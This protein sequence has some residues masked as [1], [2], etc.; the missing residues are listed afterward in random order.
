MKISLSL[1]L[2]L[3]GACVPAAAI[4]VTT[5]ANGARLNSPFWLVAS[6]TTC[7]GIT[8]VSMGYSIDH[9]RAVIESTS[10]SI[11]VTVPAGAHVLHVKCWG[12]K[13]H[14]QVSLDIS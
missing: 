6:T 4:T 2:A 3:L 1:L 9:K 8:A 14:D 7:G 11:M 5:P 10:F 12:K 13:A